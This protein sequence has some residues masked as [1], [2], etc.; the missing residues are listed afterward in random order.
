MAMLTGM[1]DISP[2]L[3]SET[4]QKDKTRSRNAA[5]RDSKM[6]T[7]AH[8]DTNIPLLTLRQSVSSP[9]MGTPLNSKSKRKEMRVN[10][11]YAQSLV[12]IR[13]SSFMH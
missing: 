4:F 2:K 3:T 7:I 6:D 1:K 13:Q 5:V 10:D 12:S 8:P 9:S 11:D